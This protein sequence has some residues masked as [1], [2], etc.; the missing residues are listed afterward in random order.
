[1]AEVTERA[2]FTILVTI[3]LFLLLTFD[4]QFGLIFS[5]FL[6]ANVLFYLLDNKVTYPIERGGSGKLK[7]A[8]WALGGF[9]A[10]TFLSKPLLSLFKIPVG[11]VNSVIELYS[12]Y[13]PFF[14]QITP[15]L[16]NNPLLTALGFGIV[17][18][19]VETVYFNGRLY[20]AITDQLKIN[21]QTFNWRNLLVAFGVIPAVATAFHFS[22]RG[23]DV[24]ATSGLVLTFLFFSI[25]QFIVIKR[26]Q[27]LDAIGMHTSAN[28]TAIVVKLGISSLQPVFLPLIFIVGFYFII[29]TH[30]V[31]SILSRNI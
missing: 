1:M 10:F 4:V 16:E 8:L 27:I 30:T 11:N 12:Q 15:A 29:R 9:F 7:T 20:E 17:V 21:T 3:L 19:V 28:T 6:I 23:I 14:S 18:T 2:T 24:A 26:R 5:L 22:V 25:S 31:S 13:I